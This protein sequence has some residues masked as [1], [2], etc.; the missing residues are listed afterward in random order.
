MLTIGN[1]G[2]GG[3]SSGSMAEGWISPWRPGRQ[4]PVSTTIQRTLQLRSS[5]R[6]SLTV[7]TAPSL[8]L[9]GHPI[10]P[11][12]ANSMAFPPGP[13]DATGLRRGPGE[14]PG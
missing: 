13:C 1:A 7:P 9:T 3:S 11:L 12:A 2:F 10:R 6:K 4:W 14:G 8:A 5:N